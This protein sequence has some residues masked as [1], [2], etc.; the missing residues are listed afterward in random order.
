MIP[1]T[2]VNW[3][4]F[5]YKFSD[6]PQ[7]AFENLTYYLFCNE[8]G[9]K[10]GIF[11]YFNQ[12]HIE[13]NP[14]RV[15]KKL[16]GFQAKY[17]AES[18]AMSSKEEELRK[19]VEGASRAYPGITTLYFYISREF[20]P[21]SE[22]DKVKPAYQ[23][24]IENIAKAIGITIEWKGL[25]NIEAQLMQD[26]RLTI[27][28]N[29]F[30]QVDSAVQE[31]CESLEKHKEDILNHIGTQVSYKNK[32][33]ILEN[34]DFDMD[35]FLDSDNQILVLDGEA[36]TGKSALIKK[37]LVDI[38]ND[39]V[40]LSFRCT[41]MD[42]S[43]KR[44]FLT[45][46][47]TLV[48][49]EVLK[50]YEETENRI[51]Y[52]DAA[53]KYFIL[54]NQQT[55]EDLF[56]MF[57]S[58]GWK[59][60]LTIRTAYIESFRNLL[61]NAVSVQSYHVAPISKALLYELSDTYGFVL[62]SDKK[63]IDMIC[64][65]FYLGLYLT[66][67]NIED[68]ELSALNRE[69]FEEKI[70]DE[71]IRNNK[72][73][74]NNLP[75]RREDILVFITKE[76]LKNESYSYMIKSGDDYEALFE[77][78][79][80]GV[81]IQSEDAKTYYHGHDVFEELVVNHI[82]TEQYKNNIT[83]KQFFEQFRT[84]LRIRKLFRGWLTDFASIE[85]HQSIIYE[86]LKCEDVNI[87]WK[88][89]ILL[90]II[91]TEKL[92]N[93]YSKIMLNMVENNY[94]LLKKTAFLINTCCRVAEHA[95]GTLNKGN[96]L[97]LRLSKP[98]GYAWESIFNFINDNKDKITWDTELVTCVV[99]I[100]DSWTK[101]Y[102][103]Q[104]KENTR[105]SGNIALYLFEKMSAS[106]E[107][108][109]TIKKDYIEK[110]KDVLLNSA[111][112][113]KDKLCNIFQIVINGIKDEDEITYPFDRTSRKLDAPR[114][115]ID[116]AEKAISD[117]YHYGKVPYA[118]PKMTLELM[119]K[120]WLRPNGESIYYSSLEMDGYFGLNEHLAYDYYPASAFKTPICGLLQA[121]QQLATDFIIEFCNK[122]G[123]AYKK[124]H[125]NID[126]RECFD[127]SICVGGQLVN[128]TA[129]T[130][131]W[132]MYRGS[133]VGSN[134]L[135]SLLM[136]FEMWLLNIVK[137]SPTNVVVDYCR[138]ILSKS[139]NVM[140]T[141]IV[142]SIVE[143]YPEKM[144]DVVCELLKTKEI[145]RLDSNRLSSERTATFA[146]F[147]ND[148]FTKERKE[149]NGLPHRKIRL[150]DIILKYQ[151]DQSELS[152]ED[153][154]KQRDKVFAAIDEATIDLDT[155]Q[156]V[157]KYA[158]YRM[159]LRRYNEVTDVNV[160]D[161]GRAICTIVPAF[162]EDMKA[163]SKESQETRD[164]HFS[165]VDLQFWSDYKFNRNEKFKEYAKYSDINVIC[166]ELGA[167]WELLC[168]MNTDDRINDDDKWLII[169][170][171]V[172]IV[173]YTSA[174][175][176]RDYVSEL[177]P[178]ERELCKQIIFSLGKMFTE[179]SRY[180][181]VQAG[182]GVDAIVVGLLT[183]ITD[184]NCHL[185]N[186]DNPMYLLLKLIL[187]DWSDDSRIINQVSSNIW[188][189]GKQYGW[190]FLY[191]FSLIAEQYD[192]EIKKNRD[193]SIND[194]F[195]KNKKLIKQAL[196]KEVS[197]YNDIDF[198][199]LSMSIMF[200]TILMISFKSKEA[201]LV[202]ELTKDIAMQLAFDDKD[203]MREKYE[204]IYGYI[205]NYVV[206][207]ADVLLYCE[208]QDRTMLINSFLERVDF[209]R[210]DNA[211]YLLKWLI[212]EQEIHGKIDEFWSVW[213]ALK[214]R[215]LELSHE[216]DRYYYTDYNGPIG[217]DRVITG[218][219]FANSE[220]R[221]NV[222]RCMLLS[223]ERME[224]FDDFIVRTGSFKAVLYSV[225]RLLNTVG[226]EPYFEKGIEWIYNLI[227]RDPE[228][229]AKLYVN[230]LYYLEEY[231]GSFVVSHRNDFRIEVVQAQRT[232]AVLEYMVN[233][234][235]QIAFFIRE[236]I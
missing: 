91:S 72:M 81:I 162:T 2:S 117:I 163:L 45:T 30:F 232:Q 158:Y 36:G 136:G 43:D 205:F 66:L 183:L 208:E 103:N 65:P 146:L 145:F 42:V 137:I 178:K 93:C 80:N 207:F 147:K 216:K 89:E 113:I 229:D 60:I 62:P 58:G 14:I 129:S 211:E 222:H 16:I 94:A 174:V 215:M 185:V 121:N 22:K 40:V 200:A 108:R 143:A 157:D 77:L 148:L 233:Q 228:C 187:K 186:E 212:Q 132:K 188:D 134:L 33:I 180:E 13:T 76:M 133:H 155:W 173:S 20:S 107:F 98:S 166:K 138:H 101:V 25:S 63:L 236:E 164:F 15:G 195:E 234:G 50:V 26:K 124:S 230:T 51:L 191:A 31:C 46:Y 175:L 9:Q 193:I 61:L 56:Q 48:I 44:N 149:S 184:D 142:V 214:P 19:A 4:A 92:R 59:I 160:G 167:V 32:N 86:L 7:R 218:Y 34:N 199:Q 115:Y 192:K 21:S 70:W 154:V 11:R 10:N 221:E 39:T 198:K 202:A 194:F 172:S 97:P 141:A 190:Q 3:K 210:N 151:T 176:L 8:Y 126:Y 73:R 67:D 27:C 235:S 106:K 105:I 217:K 122:T 29:I 189:C 111:W 110:L 41:D 87:I 206:W 71:I 135:V 231:V 153:F 204:N 220:W 85:E 116:L 125:L 74:K 6:N 102:E 99:E 123:E 37:G 140:L 152:K 130:R 197:T 109:Y 17:Y 54:E 209:V 177:E 1:E 171:Y 119:K 75:T 127:I 95:E 179:A 69:A 224:F 139:K 52:I 112:M 223:E 150:E 170:R 161:E 225:A 55:F 53:E 88:D 64:A 78:E 23:T 203:T 96:M 201:A 196:D 90:T 226:K 120:I 144:L 219:L 38:D 18:V 79:Q 57:I 213:E 47:G 227:Q 169:H 83:G 35:T 156:T 131:L 28:R 114:M 104:K 168:K 84:T 24:N 68:A 165:Y 182:N 82:F 128:Q 159:D 100:L 5:E 118:M 12:P 181:F 49:D